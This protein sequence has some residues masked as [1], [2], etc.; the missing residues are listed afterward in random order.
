[1]DS[2]KFENIEHDLQN[3][4]DT[5]SKVTTDLSRI[6][7]NISILIE[8]NNVDMTYKPPSNQY[9]YMTLDEISIKAPNT[10]DQ[11]IPKNLQIS[12]KVLQKILQKMLCNLSFNSM[13]KIET[14]YL[15]KSPDKYKLYAKKF[16]KTNTLRFGMSSFL[17]GFYN[18]SA[19]DL[20]ITWSKV[21]TIDDSQKTFSFTSNMR[22]NSFALAFQDD[23]LDNPIKGFPLWLEKSIHS[24]YSIS[25]VNHDNFY[26]IYLWTDEVIEKTFIFHLSNSPLTYIYDSMQLTTAI[27]SDIDDCIEITL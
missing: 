25:N 11:K 22:P 6:Q 21:S 12:W 3:I 1:M 26:L 15:T 16:Q 8:N 9:S 24:S 23:F 27:D 18:D 5:L 7:R 13:I 14:N 20:H 19:D 2:S 4:Q 10:T 17:V